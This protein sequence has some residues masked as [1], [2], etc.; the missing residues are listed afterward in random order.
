MKKI[1]TNVFILSFC[2]FFTL[3]THANANL[4]KLNIGILPA[5]DALLLYAAKDAGFFEENG[6]DIEIIPFQSAL[7]L[8]AAMRAKALDGHFGDIINVLLQNETGARQEIVAT[9]SY[10]NK[11]AEKPQRHFAVVGSPMLSKNPE[12]LKVENLQGKSLAIGGDTIIDYLY[13]QMQKANKIEDN[14]F[15]IEDI[16]AIP[17]RVQLLMA[18]EVDFALLP[19]P[20]V[21]TLEASGAK[22]L[23]DDTSLEEPLAVIA[24]RKEVIEK[25]EEAVQ[26]FRSALEK[27]AKDIN[28]PEN[29]EKY[30]KMMIEN[31]LLSPKVK[32]SYQLIQF[33]L[34]RLPKYLPTESEINQYIVWM[35]AKNI[36]KEKPLYA[37]IIYDAN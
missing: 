24:L 26:A 12:N 8:G 35:Q 3:N 31:N 7:E 6:L 9:S 28:M 13:T 21:T 29:H 10:A 25:N 15:Q 36:L 23:F 34:E 27:A 30:K 16:R 20:L 4:Q 5:A 19:E 17:L 33:D 18:G 2:F 37:D 14:Y 1:F 22:V 32:D 11:M